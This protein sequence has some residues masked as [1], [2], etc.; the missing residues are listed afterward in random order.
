MPAE[1]FTIAFAAGVTLG[2]WTGAWE[3]RQ[4]GIPLAFIP[5]SEL[6]QTDVLHDESADISFVRFPIDGAGLSAI[7][8]YEEAA[9]VVLPKKHALAEAESLTLADLLGE[10]R[11]NGKLSAED[12]VELVAAGGGIVILPQSIARLFARKD[13]VARLVTDAEPTRIAIAWLEEQTTDEIEE[14]VGIVR[15]RTA[16]SSRAGNQPDEPREE[17]KAREAK[18]AQKTQK[19][20]PKARPA[21]KRYTKPRKPRGSR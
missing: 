6:T 3:Q 16:R 11:V 18:L 5:T 17:R 9:V 7:P 4:P 13:V 20:Q 21:S 12:A 15:G 2:R 19:P 8:L 10:D 1:S 14:F